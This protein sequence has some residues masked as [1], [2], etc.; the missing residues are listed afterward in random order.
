MKP[1]YLDAAQPRARQ[2]EHTKTETQIQASRHQRQVVQCCVT[3]HYGRFWKPS[4]CAV[5][6]ERVKRMRQSFSRFRQSELAIALHNRACM[7]AFGGLRGIAYCVVSRGH[8]ICPEFWEQEAPCTGKKLPP[9]V[10]RAAAGIP[11]CTCCRTA[12]TRMHKFVLVPSC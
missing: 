9:I 5:G 4:I 10:I 7:K 1:A 11:S 3:M 6:A 12:P 8:T 2:Q